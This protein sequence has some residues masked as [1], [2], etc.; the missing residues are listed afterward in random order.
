M[1][2]LRYRVHGVTRGSRTVQ[3]TF[4]GVETNAEI[5]SL[6]VE[7]AWDSKDNRDH[8]SLA[9]RFVGQDIEWARQMF[10]ADAEVDLTFNGPLNVPAS[11]PEPA[12]APAEP[13]VA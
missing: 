8:G 11:A 13:A 5:P 9:L 7:L 6:D 2:T 10:V 12:I 3:V 4:E 1:S